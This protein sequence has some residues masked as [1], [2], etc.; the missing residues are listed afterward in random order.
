MIDPDFSSVPG[1]ARVM[2][3]DAQGN[4]MILWSKSIATG[5]FVVARQWRGERAPA[6]WDAKRHGE[7]SYR[8]IPGF[9]KASTRAEIEKHG[10]VLTPGRVPSVGRWIRIT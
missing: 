6:W 2:R 5:D 9:C 10:F 4:E 3:K 1:H 8:D 7:W